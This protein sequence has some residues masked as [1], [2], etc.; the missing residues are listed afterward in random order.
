MKTQLDR[1]LWKKHSILAGVDEAG[2]GPLAG[3]VVASAVI[4]PTNYF[5]PEINDSKKLSAKKRENLYTV[6][7][8]IAVSYAFGIIEHTVIDSINILNATKKAMHIAIQGLEKKPDLVLI[9]ALHLEELTYAQMPIIR[10]DSLSISIAAASILAKVKRDRIMTDYH[11]QY[12]EYGFHK[13][14][15][16]PTKGHRARIKEYGPCPIHRKTFHLI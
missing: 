3:P 8:H 16:Y 12:P 1:N 4:L 14:K 11:S 2:R 6:I 5:H 15:G 7:T 9:D 10:G 13:H